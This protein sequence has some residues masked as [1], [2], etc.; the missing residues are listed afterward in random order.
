MRKIELPQ[1]EKKGKKLEDRNGRTA[2][3]EEK[4]DSIRRRKRGRN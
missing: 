1:R 2:S 3:R 4:G